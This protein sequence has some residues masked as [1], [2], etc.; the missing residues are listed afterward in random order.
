[1]VLRAVNAVFGAGMVAFAVTGGTAA[2]HGRNGVALG[3]P[4]AVTVKPVTDVVGGH[5]ITDNYRWL[6]DQNSP[7][8]REFLRAQMQYTGGYFS[9]LGVLRER[10]TKRLTELSRVDQTGM[11]Q[12]REGALFFTRR[13]AEENQASIYMRAPRYEVKGGAWVQPGDV[14]L[15]DARKLSTDANA[16]VNIAA[17]SDNA[18]LLVYGVRHGGADEEVIHFYDVPKRADI[19]DE[20]PLARYGGFGLT[21]DAETLYYSKTQKDGTGAVFQH[22]VGTPADKDT[23]VFGGTYKGQTLGPLD[24]LGCRVSENGHWLIVTVSHGVPA[25][26]EDILLRDLRK[27]NAQFE[28]LVY[29]VDSRFQ[30]HMYHDDMFVSTDYNAPNG[31]LLRAS[32]GDPTTKSWPVVI[33]ENKSPIRAVSIVDGVFFVGRLNDVKTETKIYT[34]KGKEIGEVHY[35]TIGTGGVVQGREDSD[36]GFYTFSSFTVPPTIY[37]YKVSTSES[38]VWSESKV[39]FDSDKYEVRQVFY[40][41]N[42]GTRVPMFV[43]GRKGL[44]MDGKAPLLMTGYGGFNISETPA[45]GAEYAWWMEQGGF[46]AVPNLRGGG[47]YGETWHE[48]GMFEHKQ[49]VFDDWFAAGEYLLKNNYTTRARLAITGRSNGGLLMG[50][51][52]TQRPD[53]YG[54]ILCGYPLLDMSRYQRFLV[55]RWWTT[56]YGSAEKPD[57]AAHIL[58]YSP[59]QNIRQGVQY[60]AIMFLSGD[61]DTRVAPLH[62]RKMTAAM[63]ATVMAE[64]EEERRPVLLHYD[65]HA[66]H[67]AGVSVEQGIHDTAD[68]LTFLW[69]ETGGN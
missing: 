55:G 37:E 39:P 58:K 12:Q 5:S 21:S 1:M 62:A 23:E 67:S 68:E 43:A 20:L 32:L 27:P 29:G 25:T 19:S 2:I 42:D 51:S 17:I 7:E 24:L 6:E 50:A 18:E 33:A 57:Q 61:S 69:N 45:F 36:T 65:T 60:P 34:L 38:S 31:R 13:L 15:I 9:Q 63:Q 8:T 30:L 66:G 41:S 22:T 48:A 53:L 44:A 52:M 4:P 56:E 35:A 64:P 28:P 47:E 10:I 46:F 16:S 11:P 14:R 54:A 59:Y 26:R 49:N 40:T 3:P